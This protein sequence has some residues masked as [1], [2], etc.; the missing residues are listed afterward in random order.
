MNEELKEKIM[1]AAKVYVGSL[2][3][4]ALTALGAVLVAKGIANEESVNSVS[5]GVAEIVAGSIVYFGGQLWSLAQKTKK[6]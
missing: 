3:R 5:T 4:H 6:K 1:V 2:V